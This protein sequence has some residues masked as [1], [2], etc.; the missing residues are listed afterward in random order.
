[1]CLPPLAFSSLLNDEDVLV[2]AL[3]GC[4]TLPVF[5]KLIDLCLWAGKCAGETPHSCLITG[6]RIHTST[7]EQEQG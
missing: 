1:M 4:K 5:Q 6:V 3:T 7:E 2:S